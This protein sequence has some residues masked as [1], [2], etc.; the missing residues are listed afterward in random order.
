MSREQDTGEELL[1]GFDPLCGWCFAFGPTIRAIAAAHPDLAVR[2]RRGGL[3]VGERVAPIATSREYL[4]NGLEQVRRTAGVEAGRAFYDG[5]L[6]EGSYI[7]DSEP[8]CRAITVMEQ[9][10]PES[11]FGFAVDLPDIHYVRGLPLDDADVLAELAAA[12]GADAEEFRR[13]WPSG[14]ARLATQAGFEEAR[15]QG[16]VS[17]P[18]LLYRRGERAVIVAR[19]FLPPAAAVDR[20]AKLRVA[21]SP[22]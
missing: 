22:M 14:E 7:S 17:Y 9:I 6:A 13:R 11:V 15:A 20:I 21:G 3:V 5:L 18:T 4:I 8:P 1:Y 12:H 10:A 2:L 16:F 19:G